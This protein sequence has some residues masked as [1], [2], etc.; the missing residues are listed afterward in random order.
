MKLSSREVEMISNI[1]KARRD[2]KLS[3]WSGLIIALVAL[4]GVHI[5]DYWVSTLGLFIAVLVG[6][7]IGK[8]AAEYFRVRPDDKLIDLLLRYVNDDPEAVAQL[9]GQADA[10]E[11]AA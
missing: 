10:M 1:P 6:F 7:S 8:L 11:N 2:R 3:A 9:S 5:L 4:I